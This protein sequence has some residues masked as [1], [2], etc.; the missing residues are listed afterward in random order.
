M[1]ST[2]KKKERCWRHWCEY[3]CGMGTDEWLSN[4]GTN[5]VRAITGFAARVRSGYY[6][7]G[8]QVGVQEVTVALSAIGSTFEM[9]SRQNPIKKDEKR[10]I[11]PIELQIESYRREDPAPKVHLAVPVSLVNWLSKQ[12]QSTAASTKTAAIGDLGIIA[13]YYLL[14]VGEYTRKKQGSTR[15]VQFRYK[16]VT[17]WKDGGI[18]ENSSTLKILTMAD[19][20]TLTIDNQKNGKRGQNIHHE[21]IHG[22]NCPVKALARRINHL[23]LHSSTPETLICQHTI[24]GRTEFIRNADMVQ[25]VRVGVTALALENSGIRPEHVGSHSLRAGGAMAM[26]LN[27]ID[28]DTIRKFGR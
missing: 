7:R 1:A 15:T 9:D 21:A 17:F 23:N 2:N 10:Y 3:A 28:R 24:N 6:G 11:K 22:N 16:D 19:A 27:G 26:K 5:K 13:F 14:R 12:G 4:P 25:A 20:A 8:K 18:V